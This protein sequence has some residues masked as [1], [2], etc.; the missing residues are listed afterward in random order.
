MKW[1][2]PIYQEKT[3]TNMDC[4]E[5]AVVS[6]KQALIAWYVLLLRVIGIVVISAFIGAT[7]GH[8]HG[9]SNF[10]LQI[11]VAKLQYQ[12]E[13]NA[14]E[15]ALLRTTVAKQAGDISEMHGI[16]LGIGIILGCL[17]IAQIMFMRKSRGE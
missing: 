7:I 17:Q 12:S 4:S 2:F 14:A 6:G 10:A 16:G 3:C 8:V 1:P 15:I 13:I 5:R 11:D 9:Q